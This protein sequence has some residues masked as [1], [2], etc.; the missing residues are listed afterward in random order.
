MIDSTKGE[1]MK[2]KSEL[3]QKNNDLQFA[4]DRI[5]RLEEEVKDQITRDDGMF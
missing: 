2:L 5:S 1:F 3:E 4:N